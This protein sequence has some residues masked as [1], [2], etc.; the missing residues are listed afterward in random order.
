MSDSFFD[1]AIQYITKTINDRLRKLREQPNVYTKPEIF[2]YA[3][4]GDAYQLIFLEYSRGSDLD[5]LKGKFEPVIAAWEQYQD[6]PKSE[7][8][9]FAAIDD[10][11]ISLWLLSFA[12]IFE[13]DN[14]LLDRLLKCVANEGKDLLFE[15]LVATRVKGRKAANTLVHTRP[16]ELLYKAIESSGDVRN[17]FMTQFLKTWYKS[18]KD[19]YW[20]ECHK[21]PQGGGFFGYWS[22]E[23]AGAVKAFGIDDVTFREMPYYP[24]DLVHG[25]VKK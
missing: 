23:T 1:D 11:V 21:G 24:K 2:L 25:L 15:R 12:L 19:T 20:H 13:S 9:D 3:N 6:S 7:I 14:V 4:F 17:K 22:I 10:Y 18:L 5:I 16:Y 8:N